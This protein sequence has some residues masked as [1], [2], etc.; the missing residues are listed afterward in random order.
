MNYELNHGKVAYEA[1]RKSF[2]YTY[3]GLANFEDLE[4]EVQEAWEE[5]ASAVIDS[6]NS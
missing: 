4:P 3:A 5:V 6:Y 1:W 2:D